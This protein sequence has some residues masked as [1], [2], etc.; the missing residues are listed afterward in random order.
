[1]QPI[2]QITLPSGETVHAPADTTVRDILPGARSPEGLPYLGALVNNDLAS[3]SFPLQVNCQVRFLTF[4]DRQGQ[5]IH[6]RSLAF[7]L[8]KAVRD[9]FPEA[10]FAVRH[11]IG[12]GYYCWFQRN[13][14]P[15][16]SPADLRRLDDH[17]RD[18][19]QRDIPIARRLVSYGDALAFMEANGQTDKLNLLRYRNPPRVTIFSCEAFSDH[20]M[21]VLASSTGALT[22][23]RL[24]GCRDGLILQFPVWQE[25][26]IEFPSFTEHA[27]L[28]EIFEE[29]RRWGRVV[30]INTVGDLNEALARKRL[31]S[32][33]KISETQHEQCLSRIADQIAR[34]PARPRWILI[35]GPSSAGKTTFSKRLG[36]HL[37]VNGLRPVR[38]ETDN[39]FVDREHTPRQPDGSHDF[40]HLE[41]VDLAL[42]NDHLQRLQAGEAIDLPVFDFQQGA[43]TF[44]GRTLRLGED[45][46][47]ILEG[48]HAL[49]P[50]LTAGVPDAAKFKLYI[51]ALT[52]LT[53]DNNN[54][55]STTDIRLLRRMVRDN[56]HRGHNAIRTLQMW[57]NVRRGEERW[58]FP[59]Q[60]EARV[61]FNTSLDYEL[62]VL[63]TYAE[64][65]LV[66]VK[67]LHPEY[68]EARRLLK[69]LELVTAA[70]SD[71]VPPDSLLREFI[72]GSIFE[73]D[74]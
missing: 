6:Q 56:Q 31:D 49:N 47:V 18:L 70:P 46:V 43:R 48:I 38:L 72:G 66:E 40:E 62:A 21:G 5:R 8:A 55:I 74:A 28:F 33:I 9:L 37:R 27:H 32:V 36:V 35:A 65:L 52:Q 57:E 20:S 13:G 25:G 58:I 67:P 34:D 51:S 24:H 29:R 3:L 14:A 1:M 63:K 64:P 54:R 26:R 22:E 44:P 71:R 45:E 15:G 59:F 2:I 50:R 53:L 61:M 4:A 60:E 41:A 69:F 30:G 16:I 39:Y 12:S 10:N 73:H 68:A 11:S 42:F 7:L 23:F 19:V 17:L